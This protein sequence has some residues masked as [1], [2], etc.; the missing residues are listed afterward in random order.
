MPRDHAEDA[1]GAGDV[2]AVEKGSGSATL[3]VGD[4][5]LPGKVTANGQVLV[6]DTG[7]ITCVGCGCA[8]KAPDATKVICPDA[9]VSPGLI[10]AHDH[11][12]WMNGAPATPADNYVVKGGGKYTGPQDPEQLR[13]EHRN[14]WRPSGNAN[15]PKI[16]EPGGQATADQK[17]FGDVRMALGGAVM[18][19]ISTT[20]AKFLRVADDSKKGFFPAG[21]PYAAYETFPIGSSI[22]V[23]DDPANPDCSKYQFKT[24]PGAG[25][26]SIRTS[27]RAS[28]STHATSSSASPTRCRRERTSS[29]GARRSSTG[30]VSRLATSP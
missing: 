10:N 14:D 9:V 5:L 24:P 26:P 7:T 22:Q 4:V 30:S 20:P 8:A 19:F 27:P 6:D 17:L 15:S 2:C 1:S 28:T 11:G 12:G 3:Y 16:D 23:K 25:A 29:T 13:F 18:T 21:Q